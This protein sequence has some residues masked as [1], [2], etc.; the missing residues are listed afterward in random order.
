MSNLLAVKK[1]IMEKEIDEIQRGC[2]KLDPC[3]PLSDDKE[4]MVEF[5]LL[6]AY[7]HPV[8]KKGNEL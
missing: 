3:F 7:Q 6:T 1:Y 5:I 4:E 2:I 8:Q